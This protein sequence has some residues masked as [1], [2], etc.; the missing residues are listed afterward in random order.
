[1]GTD[2]SWHSSRDPIPL[3]P[4]SQFGQWKHTSLSDSKYR[5]T[6][7]VA[8]DATEKRQLEETSRR[9]SSA[10]DQVME[11]IAILDAGDGSTIYSNSMFSQIPF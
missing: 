9:L 7:A 5:E 2:R 8:K 4:S 10:L 3:H 6:L 1:M 11:V